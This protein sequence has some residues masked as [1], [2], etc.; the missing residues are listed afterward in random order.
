MPLGLVVRSGWWTV[1]EHRQNLDDALDKDVDLETDK[2]HIEIIIA[3]R[4]AVQGMRGLA[5]GIDRLE[6]RLDKVSTR[7]AAIA[8][9]VIVAVVTAAIIAALGRV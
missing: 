3:F 2:H 9:S 7:S 1:D 5:S 4:A 6:H 8:G